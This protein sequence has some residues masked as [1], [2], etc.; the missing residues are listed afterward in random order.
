MKVLDDIFSPRKMRYLIALAES[1]QERKV[2]RI[3]TSAGERAD[4]TYC[5]SERFDHETANANKIVEHFLAYV[6]EIVE[7]KPGGEREDIVG[8]PGRM[9]IKLVVCFSTFHIPFLGNS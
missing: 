2:V 1:D 6:Q 4:T 9:T 8:H 7:I 5:D 3:S